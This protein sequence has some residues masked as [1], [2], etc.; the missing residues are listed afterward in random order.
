[1]L[2]HGV[3]ANK[4]RNTDGATP[5]FIA[6]HKG[7]VKVAKLLLKHGADPNIPYSLGCSTPLMEAAAEGRL[8]ILRTLLDRKAIAIDAVHPDDHST[9]FHNACFY[10][11]ADCA[12]ELARR[13]R[14]APASWQHCLAQRP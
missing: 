8:P 10:G 4:A 13:R 3:D 12:A 11:H 7:Y 6:V 9:A 2:E 1:M 5:M 14:S